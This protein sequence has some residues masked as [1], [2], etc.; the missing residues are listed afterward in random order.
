MY[1]RGII[2]SHETIRQRCLKFG[3]EYAQ[4]LHKSRSQPGDK[5]HVDEVFIKINGKTQYLW[6]AVDQ[7]GLVLD[8][9]VTK[10][11]NKE[12]AKQFFL[13]L[14][15]GLKYEPRVIITDKLRSYRAAI[16]EVLPHIDHRQH[17]GLN[18]RG[19]NS[20]RSTRRRE[21]VMQKFKSPEQAQRFL[22]PFGLIYEHFKPRRHLMKATDYRQ[23]LIDR[24]KIWEDITAVTGC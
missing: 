20:H 10:R 23:I 21:K 14:L 2:V 8:I 7:N 4:K 16:R 1:E 17:K 22:S 6:R 19:E 3:D 12:A 9:L 5:W 13:K 11:R 24:F 15:K 18:N